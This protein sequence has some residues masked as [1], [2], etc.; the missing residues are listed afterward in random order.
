MIYYINSSLSI[1]S[2]SLLQVAASRRS[3]L[4]ILVLAAISRYW[5]NF[6]SMCSSGLG[7]RP[8]SDAASACSR[9]QT[10]ASAGSPSCI[11][12]TISSGETAEATAIGKWMQSNGRPNH[13]SN[14]SI[15]KAKAEQLSQEWKPSAKCQVPSAC[16]PFS[17]LYSSFSVALPHFSL[18]PLF[19]VLCAIPF[20]FTSHRKCSNW[21]IQK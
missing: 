20:D 4:A 9:W 6:C 19:V 15:S 2:L 8:A 5:T 10:N 18:C 14:K 11:A 3:A 1:S 16:S 13:S 17:T 7:T 21:K 12:A